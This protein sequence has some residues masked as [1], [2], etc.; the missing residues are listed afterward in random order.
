MCLQENPVLD[1]VRTATLDGTSPQIS[2]SLSLTYSEDTV[3][4]L[5]GRYKGLPL[6]RLDEPIESILNFEP[7]FSDFSAFDKYLLIYPL[8]HPLLTKLRHIESENLVILSFKMA[9]ESLCLCVAPEGKLQSLIY[10]TES[11]RIL[12]SLLP[13]GSLLAC[14][15]YIL[16][17]SLP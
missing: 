6:W 9:L 1:N 2:L 11:S 4:G 3:K 16:L 8:T 12:G 7:I 15:I 17:V 14:V 10:R 13:Q 5:I